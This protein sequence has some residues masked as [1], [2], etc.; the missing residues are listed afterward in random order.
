MRKTRH[1]VV[2]RDLKMHVGRQSDDNG[3]NKFIQINDCMKKAYRIL[4]IV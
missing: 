1:G 3:Q 4:L 2:I